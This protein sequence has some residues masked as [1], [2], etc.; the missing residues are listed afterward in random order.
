MWVGRPDSS[1]VVKIFRL[2][3]FFCVAS[4]SG[5]LSTINV[6]AEGPSRRERIALGAGTHMDILFFVG[7]PF[8]KWTHYFCSPVVQ[9]VKGRLIETDLG[10]I[11]QSLSEISKKMAKLFRTQYLFIVLANNQV[12]TIDKKKP[13]HI[14]RSIAPLA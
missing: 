14:L 5:R 8:V 3:C 9:V 4:A 13:G 11:E 12:F 1:P 6:D 7:E 10:N 2:G